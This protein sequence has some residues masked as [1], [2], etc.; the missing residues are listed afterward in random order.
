MSWT[1]LAMVRLVALGCARSPS[2]PAAARTLQR[3]EV[4]RYRGTLHYKPVHGPPIE[5]QTEGAA[6]TVRLPAN[7]YTGAESQ[8]ETP[9][10]TLTGAPSEIE[11]V[12]AAE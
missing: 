8:W 10:R 3:C 1:R 9:E 2:E 4:V 12:A 5:I 7:S 6:V 11:C